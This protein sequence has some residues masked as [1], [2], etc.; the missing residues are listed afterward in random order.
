MERT[1]GAF[2][3]LIVVLLLIAPS[4]SNLHRKQSFYSRKVTHDSFSPNVGV[5]DRSSSAITTWVLSLFSAALVGLTGIFPLFILDIDKKTDRGLSN[6]HKT[7]LGFAVGGLLGDVFLHLLPETF[8]RLGTNDWTA[9]MHGDEDHVA[10]GLW[11]L[12]GLLCFMLIEKL[13]AETEETEKADEKSD[14]HEEAETEGEQLVCNGTRMRDN[15]ECNGVGVTPDGVMK[16]SGHDV[17]E[18]QKILVSGYLNLVANC[19]DNFT[20]GLAISASYMVGTKVGILTTV[21][22]LLHEIPHEVGDFAILLNSGF[23]RWSATKA[24]MATASGGIVGALAGLIADEAT[25]STAWILPFTAGGFIYIAMVT[26]IP[27]LIKEQDPMQSVRQLGAILTGIIVM[28]M[29]S[30]VEDL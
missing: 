18:P 3:T 10:V 20:H 13:M 29:V 12:A 16:S 7:L 24:Q 17:K 30:Y 19:T 2:F 15:V 22:I 4:A 26:I 5:P 27:Q 6:T 9:Q 28:M 8:G 14:C 21:A 23:D 11:V 25:D 1:G